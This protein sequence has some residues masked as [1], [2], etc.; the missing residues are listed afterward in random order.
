LSAHVIDGRPVARQL[1]AKLAA[2]VDHV[3]AAGIEVG[4]ATLLVGG[5]FGATA[6]ER[7]LGRLATELAVP[8]L[9]RRLPETATQAEVIDAVEELNH[10][11]AVSG[12]LVLRPLPDHI[13][14]ATVFRCIRPE[15]DIEAVHPENAGLLALGVPRFVP[16]T[17]ASAFHLL[18]TWLEA[19]GEDRTGFY[20]R[21]TIVVVGRSNNVGKPAVSLGYERQ[22]AVLSIDEWASRTGS[23]GRHTRAADVLIVA[24]GRAGLIKA[25]HVGEHAIVIDVGINPVLDP[26]GRVR[27]VGDVEFAPVAE[28][29]RA[30]TPVPG[31]V[32]PVTDVWLL[33]NAVV[34]ANLHA[35]RPT[36]AIELSF[37]NVT[38][39][40][41]E[42]R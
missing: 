5:Q 22:A 40:V 34:A 19:V 16:S 8:Y 12:I 15:K 21:A 6:Y 20:H 23:L 30:I 27:M 18:D 39:H 38:R 26:D 32:G 24:A 4:L 3:R 41:L 17:A 36:A 33:H 1:K 14:E 9:P 7:R 42:R 10:S 11:P 35:G 2:E 28:R 31:G 37:G 25:E 13:D 29:A